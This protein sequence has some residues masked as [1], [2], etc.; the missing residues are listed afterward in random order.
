MFRRRHAALLLMAGV[1]GCRG[2]RG[3]E[4]GKGEAPAPSAAVSAT[5]S[6][7]PGPLGVGDRAAD[8]AAPAVGVP[9]SAG[10]V[11][12]AV[13][14]EGAPAYAGPT[15]V[16]EGRVFVVGPEPPAV[17]GRDLSTCPEA[18][19]TRG[20]LYRV[21]D[22]L[23]SGAR[24]LAGAVVG[25]TGYKAFVPET[26]PA[27]RVVW[28]RC[29]D[30]PSA[31]TLTFGQRLELVNR[32]GRLLGPFLK[33]SPG[34]NVLVAQPGGEA[35]SVY[36]TLPGRYTLS[37]RLGAEDVY[38]AD[39]YV[40]LQPLHAVT[41]AAGRFRIEGVPTGTVTVH[42]RLPALARETSTPAEVRGDAVTSVELTLSAADAGT[43]PG[44]GAASA[45]PMPANPTRP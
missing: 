20:R 45:G 35:V 28:D 22:P 38:K 6:A 11:A 1:A 37:D 13:N 7:V 27:K 17:R 29:E 33:E 25:V 8:G 30:T 9:L 12:A 44:P 14:P 43:S 5:R 21:G 18:V 41:D 26:S 32:T 42:A 40:L 23:P 15:G 36:P 19:R 39:V 10:E 3:Q 31:I 2:S 16:L 4:Q 34:A 24:P